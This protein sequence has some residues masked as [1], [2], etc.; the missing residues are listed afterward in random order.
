MRIVHIIRTGAANLASVAAALRR[1]GVEP[2]VT[3]D[4]STVSGAELC[5]LPGVGAFGP[6]IQSLRTRGIDRAIIERVNQNRPLLAI[7][8][9]M[10]LLLD[11]SDEAPGQRGLAI[12]PC[13]ARRF[14]SSLR[15]PQI[16]WNRVRPQQQFD[17]F[18]SGW[19]Y[20]ANSY[21]LIEP[22]PGYSVA[23][24]DYGGPF[25]AAMQR[26]RVIVACQFHPELS[27]A[28]G[29]KLI[30]RWIDAAI[31]GEQEACT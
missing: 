17:A 8:L 15:I 29:A 26:S 16:G 7:C 9:G 22:P 1:A 18:D 6:A 24:A 21:R 27:G 2:V 20:F 23:T 28:W 3:D 25:V 19:A 5:V 4:A 14:D 31:N 13:V 30:Q 12:V 10:Q 11:A